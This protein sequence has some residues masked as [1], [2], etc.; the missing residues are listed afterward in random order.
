MQHLGGSTA[1]RS[2]IAYIQQHARLF[3]MIQQ[4]QRAANLN[5]KQPKGQQHMQQRAGW[6][7]NTEHSI[8][9][10]RAYRS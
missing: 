5:N 10:A 7:G 8:A 1:R 4:Q 6:I 2:S 9:G 3:L